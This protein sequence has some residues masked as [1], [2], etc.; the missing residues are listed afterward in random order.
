LVT[1]LLQTF[2]CWRRKQWKPTVITCV[3][4]GLTLSVDF[5]NCAQVWLVTSGP[6]TVTGDGCI[7]SPNFKPGSEEHDGIDN[8]LATAGNYGPNQTCTFDLVME[9]SPAIQVLNFVRVRSLL[10]FRWNLI[11]VLIVLLF[12]NVFVS[13]MFFSPKALQNISRN[14]KPKPQNIPEWFYNGV[15]RFNSK[16]DADNIPEACKHVPALF[17]RPPGTENSDQRAGT[18]K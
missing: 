5:A 8:C 15:D 1:Y 17:C 16:F 9:S 18:G 3:C 4:L 2:I 10:E 7:V 12:L 13:K 14:D 11:V 6:C